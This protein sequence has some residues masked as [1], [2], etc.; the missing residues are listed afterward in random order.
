MNSYEDESNEANPLGS[1]KAF[2]SSS[3]CEYEFSGNELK[4][5]SSSSFGSIGDVGGVEK[6]FD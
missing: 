3:N 1:P 5:S 2:I 6:G 4:S